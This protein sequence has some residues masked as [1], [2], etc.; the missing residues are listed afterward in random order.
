[1]VHLCGFIFHSLNALLY[2]KSNT[3]FNS[4]TWIKWILEFHLILETE[5]DNFVFLFFSAESDSLLC[6][7]YSIGWNI[8]VINLLYIVCSGLHHLYQMLFI[9]H[10]VS[11][12]SIYHCFF[13]NLCILHALNSGERIRP[14]MISPVKI[15]SVILGLFSFLLVFRIFLPVMT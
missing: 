6:S 1:M 4:F 10:F 3:Y 13:D 12:D 9:Y 14:N 11:F 5:L 2:W 7:C 15:I 8:W